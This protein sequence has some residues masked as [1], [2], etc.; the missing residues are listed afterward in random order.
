MRD[1]E[2]KQ[3]FIQYMAD[4]PDE[5]FWQSVRN[6]TGYGAVGVSDTIGADGWNNYVDTFHFEGTKE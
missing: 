4:H 1:E 2:L 5:R 3:D 6:F